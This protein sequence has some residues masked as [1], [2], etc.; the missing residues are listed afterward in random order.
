MEPNDENGPGDEQRPAKATR[1]RAPSAR[2]RP[3]KAVRAAE[4][5]QQEQ[6]SRP[7]EQQRNGAGSAA[8]AR[9]ATETQ[10]G[11]GQ[12]PGAEPTGASDRIAAD[13][14]TAGAS[15]GDQP[16]ARGDT[17]GDGGYRLRDAERAAESAADLKSWI[18]T[19]PE[20]REA[21]REVL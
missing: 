14:S 8:A 10:Q 9:D 1:K 7:D 2:K 18:D 20:D 5:E 11:D 6:G 15:M 13:L 12:S 3:P 21:P 4:A 16:A 17:G 19:K